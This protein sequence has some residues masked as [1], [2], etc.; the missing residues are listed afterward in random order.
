MLTVHFFCYQ[1]FFNRSVGG[2]RSSVAS[3]LRWLAVL[4][5]DEEGRLAVETLVGTVVQL[6][7]LLLVVFTLA[8]I[9]LAAVSL[10]LVP[11]MH[12]MRG[13]GSMLQV[14]FIS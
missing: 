1:A 10:P 11:L 2:C 4:Q 9:M 7:V 3:T 12:S 14:G 5:A 6:V 13:K 8:N